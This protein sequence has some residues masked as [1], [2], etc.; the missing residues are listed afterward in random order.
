M[1]FPTSP[2]SGIL[3][4]L[5]RFT[6]PA[7][8]TAELILQFLP[9]L[10][11]A[12]LAPTYAITQNLD[13]T[14]WQLVIAAILALD[15]VGGVLT[16]ATATAK[17]WYHRPGQGFRQHFNFVLLHILHVAVVAWLFRG[18]DLLF[19]ILVSG[20]LLVA[21]VIILQCSSYLQRP[22]ALGLYGLVLLGSIYGVTPTPGLEW[23][24]NLFFLKILVSHLLPEEAGNTNNS[25]N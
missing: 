4:V 12:A 3:G 15:L 1:T 22:I 2:R 5:D 7:A 6:G 16:N 9:S 11:A 21:S 13:W 19:F 17:R 10:I 18:G 14:P 8:T 24:L 23:F 20:Y 25:L